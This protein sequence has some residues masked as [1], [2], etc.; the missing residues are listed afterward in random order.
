MRKIATTVLALALLSISVIAVPA[1][2]A[3]SSD[4]VISQLYGAGGNAGA[5]LRNDYVELYNRSS[6]P[7]LLTGWSLQYTSATGNS[8]G[9]NKVNLTGTIA[10]HRY[11]L[12]QLASG[13]AV[14]ALLPPPDQSSTAINMSGTTG[15]IALVNSTTALAAVNCPVSASIVDFVGFGATAD[16]RE[17]S[18]NA[19]APSTT[20]SINRYCGYTNHNVDTDQNGTDFLVDAANP[21]NSS[22]GDASCSPVPVNRTT[23]GQ[24]KTIYR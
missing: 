22:S 18:A 17:G 3:V 8:W 23:W 24:I 12:V 13:G 5:A 21:R 9:S 2:H 16:C 20:N 7:V 4:V 19:P 15:K 1:A 6:S 14:G 11:F 10:G